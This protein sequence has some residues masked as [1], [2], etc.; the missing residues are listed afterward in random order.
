MGLQWMPHKQATP[1][2]KM[3]ESDQTIILSRKLKCVTRLL[4]TLRDGKTTRPQFAE[5]GKRLMN[6][7]W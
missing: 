7:I 4:T 6:I 3:D 2:N 5:A 1:K